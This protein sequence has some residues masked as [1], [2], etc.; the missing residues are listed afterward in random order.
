ML[1][2]MCWNVFVS[3]HIQIIG[4]WRKT[5]TIF[6]WCWL[7]VVGQNWRL[8]HLNLLFPKSLPWQSNLF[9]Y[10]HG[11][12]TFWFPNLRMRMFSHVF[13]SWKLLTR[14]LLLV[15]F[16]SRLMGESWA[17]W[18]ATCTINQIIALLIYYPIHPNTCWGGIGIWTPKH[19]LRRL[20]RVPNTLSQGIWRILD[21]QT[22]FC[23][24]YHRY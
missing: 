8:I 9:N 3:V 6:R 4:M 14:V 20:L 10:P 23:I 12:S 7:E 24:S 15:C 18:R 13:C 17:C 21:V 2:L 1:H 16:F 22:Y 11:F 19:L 5:H